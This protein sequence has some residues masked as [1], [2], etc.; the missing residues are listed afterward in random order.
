MHSSPKSICKFSVQVFRSK[1]KYPGLIKG[2]KSLEQH[3]FFFSNEQHTPNIIKFQQIKCFVTKRRRSQQL[4]HKQEVWSPEN[5][6]YSLELLHSLTPSL[7]KRSQTPKQDPPNSIESHFIVYFSSWWL[8]IVFTWNPK[9]PKIIELKLKNIQSMT[10]YHHSVV[11]YVNG[12]YVSPST[13]VY[14]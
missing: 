2:S 1:L 7:P 11:M 5:T 9:Q 12:H 8:L 10:W 4:H 3:T 6:D 13:Y 14:T